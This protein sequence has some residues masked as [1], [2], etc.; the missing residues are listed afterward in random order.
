MDKSELRGRG[1]Q[2]MK[3][4]FLVSF[5]LLGASFWQAVS[6]FGQSYQSFFSEKEY[7]ERRV[8]WR[9]GPFRISPTIQLR[10]V[11]YDGN[12]YYKRQEEHPK[13][14]YTAALSPQAVVY[15]LFRN[16]LILSFTERPEYVFYLKEKRER[17]WNNSYSPRAKVLLLNRF[18]LSADYHFQ[19]E[20]I[21]ATSEFDVRAVR[22][23]NGYTGSLFYE[24]ARGTSFGFLASKDNI[25]YEDIT[26]PG[27]ELYVSRVLNRV[28]T[29]GHFEFY[30]RVFSDSSFFITGGHTNY[31]FERA[32]ARWRDS[33]SYQLYFGIRFPL[34]GRRRGTL[35]IGYKKLMP[36]EQGKKGFSGLAGNTNLN[37]RT[38][39]FGFRAQFIRDCFFSYWTN[40]IYFLE[41]R[42]GAGIS[43]YLTQYL[44]LDYDLVFGR[45]HYPELMLNRMP[46]GSYQEIFR[47]D[48]NYIHTAGIVFRILRNIGLGL[49]VNYWERQSNYYLE[50][51][52]RWFAGGYVTYEF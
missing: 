32:E 50:N 25:R 13:S 7:I 31:D 8:K 28:E 3:R 51:R 19:R 37:F 20:R 16:R 44:R 2:Q 11:G 15:L 24:T 36:R 14:D 47:E 26:L 27:E 38:G 41:N 6:I 42:Y 17:S 21:R 46:D 39:R 18:V 34:L 9:I 40:N 10:D 23:A 35:S 4:L 33:Y 30:Y 22:E 48:K 12:V 43:F 52:H 1:F 49:T 5:L 45:S 29:S